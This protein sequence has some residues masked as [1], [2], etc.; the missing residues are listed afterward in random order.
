MLL[1][2]KLT[3]S[4]LPVKNVV[5]MTGRAAAGRPVAPVRDQGSVS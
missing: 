3:A 2:V 1:S 4:T 5:N